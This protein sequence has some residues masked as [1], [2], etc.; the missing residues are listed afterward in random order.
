MFKSMNIKKVLPI[1]IIPAA[2]FILLNLTF[3]LAF[4]FH[5]IFTTMFSFDMNTTY[6][7]IPSFRHFLFL[8]FI[9]FISWLILRSKLNELIK[10]IFSTVPTAVVLV[11]AGIFLYQ[12]P[13][14]VYGLGTIIYGC[15]VFFLYKTKKPWTFYYAVTLVA[16]AL[17][18]MG[19]LGID[20]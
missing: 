15:I 9:L 8:L 5:S 4:L 13:A 10:A 2:G 12:W 14:I 20:I 19:I 1:V 11:T 16:L 7:W 17:L 18:T 3:M 6:R